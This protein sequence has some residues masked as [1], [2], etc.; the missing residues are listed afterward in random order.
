V[1][2]R[3]GARL[4]RSISREDPMARRTDEVDL[5]PALAGMLEALADA[6]R[7]AGT[8][9]R[10]T[11]V[12]AGRVGARASRRAWRDALRAGDR[13]ALAL[14]VLRGAEPPARTRRRPLEYVAVAA[15]A[16]AAGAAAVFAVTR[17]LKGRTAAT[18][19]PTEAPDVVDGPDADP[20]ASPDTTAQP[21]TRS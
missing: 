2:A 7:Y 12:R 17:V 3:D 15:A 5:A 4:N 8:G 10:T 1:S 21:A 19:E 20:A 11:G 6:G 18:A 13:A 14:H 9:L 16:G